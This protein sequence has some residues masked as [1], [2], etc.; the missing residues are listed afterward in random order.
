MSIKNRTKFSVAG[1][2]SLLDLVRDHFI[3]KGLALVPWEEE[4]D[5]CLIGASLMGGD[6]IPLAQLELQRMWVEDKPVLLLSSTTLSSNIDKVP[7]NSLA[8]DFHASI[9]YSRCAEHV[10]YM[11]EKQT[12]IVR[13]CNVYGPD[14][15][16]GLVYDSMARARRNETLRNPSTRWANTSFIYQDD[17]FKYIDLLLS[18]KASGTFDIGSGESIT[19]TNL[20][21]NIW[22][23]VH[24]SDTEPEIE[25]RNS[26]ISYDYLPDVSN[27]VAVTGW[28]PSVSLRSGLFR[29]VN[30]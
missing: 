2:H 17:F 7:W 4:R 5:F 1:T 12:I 16:N 28:T 8:P 23:F 21:R 3:K 6:Q 15:T 30:Q 26:T 10:F 25:N 20:L 24:G 18:E 27:L 29:L 14:I 22:K 11:R 13:P 19:Y 9:L